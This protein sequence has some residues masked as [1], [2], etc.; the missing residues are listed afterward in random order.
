MNALCVVTYSPCLLLDQNAVK[1]LHVNRTVVTR[2]RLVVLWKTYQRPVNSK[3]SWRHS[4]QCEWTQPVAHRH[5][6]CR[7]K[8]MSTWRTVWLHFV[9][10]RQRRSCCHGRSDQNVLA[11][12]PTNS[13]RSCCHGRSD[14][15]VLA[16]IPTNWLI[17]EER[18]VGRHSETHFSSRGTW[19][20]TKT[21]YSSRWTRDMT[22]TY[23]SSWW[24]RDMTEI[25]VECSTFVW[26]MERYS[27]D[28][29]AHTTT[30]SHTLG[31]VCWLHFPS[32]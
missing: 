17:V 31:C 25:P 24:I 21:C 27:K 30:S 15:N 18:L 26:L 12:I 4:A 6:N 32:I 23:Y 14:Q 16:E 5:V 2:C 3:R 9:T 1:P 28:V 10:G 19:D 8:L 7:L 11:E 22:E 20:M 29:T 13:R